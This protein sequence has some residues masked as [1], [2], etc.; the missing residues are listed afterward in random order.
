MSDVQPRE[1]TRR[2]FL[3]AS[4]TTLLTGAFNPMAVKGSVDSDDHPQTTIRT[5]EWFGDDEIVLDF[6]LGWQIDVRWMDGQSAPELS[7]DQMRQALHSTIDT[8]RIA[9]IADGAGR[10]VITF[11]DMSRP[12]PTYRVAPLVIEELHTA[13]V[14]DEDI[15]FQAAYGT[16]PPLYQQ[17]MV[18]KLGGDIVKKYQVWNH[19]CF[20]GLT[21]LGTSSRGNDVRL[22]SRFMSAD[23]K[24]CISCVKPHYIAGYGG[25]A[26]SI[27]PGVAW[28]KTAGY[29]HHEVSP[30]SE[31]GYGIVNSDV[32]LDMEEAARM[33]GL[34]VSV[35]IT[36]NGTRQITGLF[37]GDV[38]SAHRSAAKLAHSIG[39]TPSGPLADV[40][41]INSYP[42]GMQA[43]KE[44]RHAKTGLKDGGSVVLI[45]D[46]PT[47]QSKMH[48]GAWFATDGWNQP[49]QPS[50]LPVAQASQ[51]IVF[52]RYHSKWDE[53]EFSP[54]VHFT[55]QWEEVVYLL[56]ASHGGNTL[57]TVYPTAP[58]QHE[59]LALRL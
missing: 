46:T 58:F 59:S 56:S 43:T 14:K 55:T 19:D 20:H 52:N 45:Q 36:M 38:V 23:V 8:P 24:I 37:A 31:T 22:N 40:V 49:R 12:T 27:V 41:V 29:I 34:D 50:G 25:G 26:K 1:I 28:I 2:E 32:R 30:N 15:V 51:V 4:A 57:V 11:D 48:F 18:Q 44:L 47:G 53:R 6:P 16:H 42:Q 35:N 54:D 3:A 5:A 17:Q 7:D 33:A 9:E 21:A 13:G 10:V 39:N